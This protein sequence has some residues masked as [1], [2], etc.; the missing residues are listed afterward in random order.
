MEKQLI[1][2][3]RVKTDKLRVALELRDLVSLSLSQLNKESY[4]KFLNNLNLLIFE[5]VLHVFF[6]MQVHS[7]DTQDK[8]AAIYAI[9]A[10]LDIEGEDS[11]VENG[12][13]SRC[14]GGY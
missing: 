13:I 12:K 6:I 5:L 7:S 9:D 2:D 8:V 3:L 4:I 11:G 14:K 1:Q 10:L